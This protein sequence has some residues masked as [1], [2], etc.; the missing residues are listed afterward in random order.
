MKTDGDIDTA[1]LCNQ[2]GGSFTVRELILAATSCYRNLQVVVSTT[3]CCQSRE[4][5]WPRNGIVSRGYIYA[6]GQAHFADM[7]NYQAPGLSVT[8]TPE[9]VTIRLG[10]VEKL[11]ERK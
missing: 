10:N 4:E 7:E 3:S 2:C 6:A 5:L 11:I 8:Y 1:I 9:H